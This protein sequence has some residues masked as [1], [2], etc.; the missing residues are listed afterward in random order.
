[1]VSKLQFPSCRVLHTE[2]CCM[3]VLCRMVKSLTS[4]TSFNVHMCWSEVSGVSTRVWKKHFGIPYLAIIVPCNV[5]N[6]Y[7]SFSCFVLILFTFGLQQACAF[8]RNI[9]LHF[10]FRLLGLV[11]LDFW[12]SKKR[13]CHKMHNLSSCGS[14]QWYQYFRHWSLPLPDTLH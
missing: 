8:W 4:Y 1:M 7:N 9:L 5:P 3:T 2:V 14:S 6:A 10:V 12:K 13:K 11:V